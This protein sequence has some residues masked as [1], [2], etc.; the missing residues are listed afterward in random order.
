MRPLFYLVGVGLCGIIFIMN[1]R[2][3]ILSVLMCYVTVWGAQADVLQDAQDALDV[4]RVACSGL[5]DDI[6]RVS[7]LAVAGV[8]TN[9]AGAIAGGTAVGVGAA[10]ANDDKAQLQKKVSISCSFK[11]VYGYDV[12]QVTRLI[13][14]IG[15]L[16]TERSKRLGNW[17]TGLMVGAGMT[18]IASAVLA[19]I[20]MNQSELVQHVTACNAALDHL[21]AVRKQLADAGINPFSNPVRGRVENVVNACDKFNVADVQK[22]ERKEKVV[23][24]SS[25][26]GAAVA[27]AGVVTSASANSDKM[28]SAAD[29]DG[30]QKFNKLNAASNALAGVSTAGSLVSTVA[31]GGVVKLARQMMRDATRCAEALNQ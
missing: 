7:G 30:M 6:S 14:Q 13:G 24:G 11:E 27:I 1:M 16:Y 2:C 19:G 23:V 31:G 28:R 26:A 5:S 3:L 21:V 20:N 25:A 10:K 12:E 18:H 15:D 29:V 8:A 22:I 17:R 4:A 9:A